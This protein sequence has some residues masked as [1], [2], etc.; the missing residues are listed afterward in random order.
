MLILQFN[1]TSTISH[2]IKLQSNNFSNSMT[3]LVLEI[4]VAIK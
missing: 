3:N 2:T 1:N 4:L